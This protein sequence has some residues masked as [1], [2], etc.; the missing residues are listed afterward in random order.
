MRRGAAQPDRRSPAVSVTGESEGQPEFGPHRS[1]D[2][3][4][5]V[6]DK[7]GRALVTLTIRAYQDAE[8]IETQA[9]IDTAFSGELVIPR[10]TIEATI[11]FSAEDVKLAR[12]PSHDPQPPWSSDSSGG[13]IVGW[14]SSGSA[15]SFCSCSSSWRFNAVSSCSKKAFR[16]P[17]Y[18]S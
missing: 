6:V 11:R 18:R 16:S 9:W 12:F 8:P 7:Y 15:G 4:N 3:V 14:S 1:N 5:G 17:T 2:S 10:R 13:S